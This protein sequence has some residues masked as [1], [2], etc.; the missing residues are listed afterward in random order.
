MLACATLHGGIWTPCKPTLHAVR[1][2][3]HVLTPMARPFHTDQDASMD[4]AINLGKPCT[5]PLAVISLRARPLTGYI[6][7]KTN[8][9]KHNAMP[10]PREKAITMGLW[11]YCRHRLSS[12]RTSELTNDRLEGGDARFLCGSHLLGYRMAIPLATTMKKH[13][14]FPISDVVSKMVNHP[15]ESSQ[16]SVEHGNRNDSC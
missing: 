16:L 13:C 4:L 6:T 2:L 9:P 1:F 12:S 15:W 14:L 11:S 5:A 3:S 8:F 10:M 7:Q